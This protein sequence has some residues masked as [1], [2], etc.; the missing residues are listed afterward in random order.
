[1]ELTTVFINKDVSP[2]SEGFTLVELML[3]LLVFMVIALG[4]AAGE[5]TALR[6]QSGN[7]YRDEALRLAD[8]ELTR[9]K[10]ERFSSLSEADW[11]APDTLKVNMRGG[12]TTFARSFRIRDIA[13]S[14]TEMK[15]ID[16]MVGWTQG[17][18]PASA[19]TNRNRQAS[20]ST[21]I[22]R[23]D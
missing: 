13:A 22:T 4:L 12:S 16:V 21:I 15:R 6:T 20:L 8:D 19:P 18:D 2:S 9:L 1:M 3:A 17:K 10:S 7:L 14:A 23:T 5:I 11:T